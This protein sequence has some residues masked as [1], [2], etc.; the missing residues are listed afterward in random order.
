MTIMTLNDEQKTAVT[1][2]IEAG[3][4]LSDVQKRLREDFGVALTY[5]ETRFLVDDLKLTLK[6]EETESAA[7]D[8]RLAPDESIP[9]TPANAIPPEGMLPPGGA[10]TSVRVTIDQI[11]KPGA[12]ISGKVTFS[13]DETAHWHLDQM[14]RLG[15]DPTTPGY[16]PTE[17]DIISFQRELQ[18]LA[19]SQGY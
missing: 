14:G 8:D 15:L 6:E 3:T 13:D 9:H 7:P 16:H 5:M 2:W 10:G 18:R 17:P 4:G 12:L 1:A 11:T 19:R